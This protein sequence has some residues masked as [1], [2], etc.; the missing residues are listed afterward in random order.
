[1]IFDT[2]LTT[3]N[4]VLDSSATNADGF[5]EETYLCYDDDGVYTRTALVT[6]KGDLG[7]SF[8]YTAHA[9]SETQTGG[10]YKMTQSLKMGEKGA[11]CAICGDWFKTSD[12]TIVNGRRLCIPNKCA[13]E[14][15][16]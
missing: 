5:L 2:I 3:E 9:T 10:D 8:R 13:S 12:F 7:I 16:N 11:Q 14:V 4:A 1:M 15:R 6:Y